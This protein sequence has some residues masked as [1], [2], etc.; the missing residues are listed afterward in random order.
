MKCIIC[1]RTIKVKE[2]HSYVTVKGNNDRNRKVYACGGCQEA[3]DRWID[4][5]AT[6]SDGNLLET[7]ADPAV[8]A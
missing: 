1:G 8:P 6:D 3:F 2:N 5:R 4:S 7:P